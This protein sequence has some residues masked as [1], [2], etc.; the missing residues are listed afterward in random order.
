MA[1][2]DGATP[3]VA[4]IDARGRHSYVTSAGSG[5][6]VGKR[7]GR[8]CVSDIIRID[9]ADYGIVGSVQEP[10]LTIAGIFAYHRRQLRTCFDRLTP[11][12]LILSGRGAPAGASA[13]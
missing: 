10:R 7:P 3:V 13:F 4:G 2:H 1:D 12:I 8:A 9:D 11:R 6:S 5:P